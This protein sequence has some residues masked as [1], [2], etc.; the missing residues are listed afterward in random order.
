MGLLSELLE[1]ERMR[2]GKVRCR[3]GI[4]WPQLSFARAGYTA[5]RCDLGRIAHVLQRCPGPSASFIY[6]SSFKF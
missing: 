4:K 1:R 3:T 5:V 2:A 6:A